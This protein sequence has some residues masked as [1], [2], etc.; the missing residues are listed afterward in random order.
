[1]IK[2]GKLLFCFVKTEDYVDLISKLWGA[3]EMDQRLLDSHLP[4]MMTWFALMILTLYLENSPM[5]L[6]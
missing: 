2:F 3:I 5:Q 1:M 6:S 4:I